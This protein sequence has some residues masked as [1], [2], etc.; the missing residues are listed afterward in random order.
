MEKSKNQRK[1][2]I[3][4]VG[5]AGYVG[6][7]LV[8]VLLMD[9]YD[10]TVYDN[11]LYETR[12]LKKVKFVY[13]DI[14]EKKKL[15]ILLSKFDIVIWLA[16]IVGDGACAI[17]PTLTKEINTNSVKWV[18]DNYK[19]KLIFL[20]TASVYGRNN[21]LI[22]ETA[23]PNPL[24]IYAVTKLEAEEYVL[25]HAEN[26]LV[27]RLGTLFGISDC[28]SRIR[29]DLVVN[30]LTRRAVSHKPLTVFGGEQWR[31][32]LHVLDVAYAINFGIYN[33]ISGLFNLHSKNYIIKDLAIKISNIIKN[34]SII[35]QDMKFE[36]QRNYRVSSNKFRKE[37]WSPLLELEYGILEIEKL[38]K[39]NRIRDLYDSSYS[40]VCHMKSLMEKNNG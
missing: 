22:D 16:A 21:N 3:L 37:G 17:D 12:F 10:V 38:I 39:E 27:F 28:F 2:K 33:N 34:T 13:G 5:G 14:R 32:L 7:G 6:G 24:S 25:K 4:V 30:F 8:D 40:N 18:V 29:F 9:N 15:K 20:S 36:D 19:G 31:P 23:T 35:L 26:S 11:L 1:I